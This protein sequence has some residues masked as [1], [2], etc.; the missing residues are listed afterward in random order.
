[1]PRVFRGTAVTRQYAVDIS[2]ISSAIEPPQAR[3]APS[4]SRVTGI[5]A[6]TFTA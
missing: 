2:R 6:L 4:S 5:I 1:M 3:R